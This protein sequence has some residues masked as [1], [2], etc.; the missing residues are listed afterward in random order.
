MGRGKIKPG[1]KSKTQPPPDEE[2]PSLNDTQPVE[3]DRSTRKQKRQRSP[4]E[5]LENDAHLNKRQNCDKLSTIKSLTNEIRDILRLVLQNHAKRS[6]VK[7]QLDRIKEKLHKIDET[8]DASSTEQ[9]TELQRLSEMDARIKNIETLVQKALE[10]PLATAPGVAPLSYASAARSRPSP[11]SERPVHLMIV[12]GN[13]TENGDAVIKKVKSAVRETNCGAAI[14]NIKTSKNGKDAVIVL[15]TEEDSTKLKEALEKSPATSNFDART[16]ARRLPA[17]VI[18]G[19]QTD[20]T[21]EEIL[22]IIVNHESNKHVFSG[23]RILKERSGNQTAQDIEMDTEDN[24]ETI[25]LM[26]ARSA[27]RRQDVYDAVVQVTPEL[28]K[29]L[30]APHVRLATRFTMVQVQDF[31]PVRVCFKCQ[32]FGHHSTKCNAQTDIC[33][34]CA[35]NHRQQACPYKDDKSK[36]CCVNCIRHN[37]ALMAMAT[38]SHRSITLFNTKHRATDTDSCKAYKE[39]LAKEK[40]KINY[41]S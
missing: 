40:V 28:R 7:E 22:D 9:P 36:E 19:I 30:L 35:G 14:K 21:K 16:P 12:R 17:M 39:E 20:E 2:W 33:P 25:R 6:T 26:F 3:N 32:G 41:G 27:G 31:S 18:R 38:T 23:V 5:P 10:K 34:M 29:R 1:P 24:A 4:G 15:N 11:K 13:D 8:A 37:D